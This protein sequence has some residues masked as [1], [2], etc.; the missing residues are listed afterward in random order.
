[1]RDDER[2][3]I[4]KLRRIEQLFAR[5][6]TEGER[7]AAAHASRRIRARL[8]ALEQADPPVEYRFSL[9]DP[10]SRSL[11]IAILRRHGLRPYR[12]H[13][14]R[15]TTVMVRVGASFVDRTLWPE[16][17]QSQA[18]LH[19]HFDTVAQRVIA[20]AVGETAEDVEVRETRALGE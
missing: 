13:G 3:L 8:D 11:F 20:E 2:E 14:Q 1:M 9:T 5:P 7:A 15:R 10:W 4:E 18:V 19:Q 17:Q 16:Y 12:Y 6:G